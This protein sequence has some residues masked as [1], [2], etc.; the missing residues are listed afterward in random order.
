MTIT[1]ITLATATPGGG[2]PLYGGV[3]AE[4]INA[5]DTSLAVECRNTKGSTE[6]VPLL[7]AGAVDL[8]LVTGEVAIEPVRGGVR[9]ADRRGDVFDRR[10]VCRARRLSG[11][12][13]RRSQGQ[14]GSVRC[15]RIGARDPGA[16]HTRRA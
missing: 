8:G 1:S 7:E 12:K 15:C 5:I 3:V 11:A 14:A 16:L 6:N 10:H 4:V 2:F 9:G 13:D